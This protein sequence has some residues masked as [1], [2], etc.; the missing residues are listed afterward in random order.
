MIV[1][2]WHGCVPLK[3]AEDF[4]K[5]LEKTGV[6]HSRS[7]AGNIGAYVRRETQGDWESFLSGNLLEGS[8]VSKDFRGRKL[9]RGSDVSG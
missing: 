6:E 1:R 7:T 2:T 3:H 4:A 5:H 9:S 8:A